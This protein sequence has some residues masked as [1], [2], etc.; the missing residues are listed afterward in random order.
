LRSRGAV[1]HSGSEVAAEQWVQAG[2]AGLRMEPRRLTQCSAY[3][4]DSERPNM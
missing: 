4:L 2:V 1:S 3:P